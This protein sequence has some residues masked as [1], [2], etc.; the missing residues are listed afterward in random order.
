MQP[1]IAYTDLTSGLVH[2]V[3]EFMDG[4]SLE[5]LIRS[6]GCRDESVLADLSFQVYYIV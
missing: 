6:G 3:V 4:G 2:L 5:D 1:N